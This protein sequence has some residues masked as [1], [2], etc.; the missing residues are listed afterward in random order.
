[1]KMLFFNANSMHYHFRR[2]KFYFTR[3]RAPS[4]YVPSCHHP[5]L[6]EEDSRYHY[7]QCY[8][9]C[10]Y[11]HFFIASLLNTQKKL[12]K[13]FKILIISSLTAAT[14]Y[15]VTFNK[16]FNIKMMLKWL[17]ISFTNILIVLFTYVTG[18]GMTTRS[19]VRFPGLPQF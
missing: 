8:Q 2:M 14:Q 15:D 4:G 10:G 16:Y 13:R 17:Q 1:M 9:L 18:I 11:K 5:G 12:Q 19:R 6:L 7:L 3:T